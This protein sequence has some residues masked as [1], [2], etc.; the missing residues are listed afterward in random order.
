MNIKCVKI[1]AGDG[2]DIWPAQA[3][4]HFYL[5]L[6]Y[7]TMTSIPIE[8]IC[9]ENLVLKSYTCDLNQL[10]DVSVHAVYHKGIPGSFGNMVPL[11]TIARKSL[12]RYA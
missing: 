2:L 6:F 3:S 7:V 12:Y 1:W 5:D 11:T 8:L 9:I 10:E 4:N